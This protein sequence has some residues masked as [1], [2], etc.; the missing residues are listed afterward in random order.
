MNKRETRRAFLCALTASPLLAK[1]F[2]EKH[3][4]P[5][6]SE[7]EIDKMLTDS[8][9]ARS[10]STRFRLEDPRS[11]DQF[12]LMSARFGDVNLPPGIGLPTGGMGIP[13][14]GWPGGGT[15]GGQYPGSSPGAGRPTGQTVLTEA[16]LTMRWSSAL[17][18]KQALVLDELGYGDADT[19]E[20]RQVLTREETEYIVEIFGLPTIVVHME[21]KEFEEELAAKSFLS[22]KDGPRIRAASARVPVHGTYRS[23]TL[24]FPKNEPITLNAKQVEVAAAAGPFE[25]NQKFK[26]ASMVY[27]G[28]LEL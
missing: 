21:R 1:G 23:I 10:F 27:N 12:D 25:F 28:R 5:E 9:W 14:G 11:R 7:E 22:R 2:W 8:P 15:G 24:R 16:Y 17:P 19:P 13:G 20:A 26:L 18:I 3:P 4:F 6:W